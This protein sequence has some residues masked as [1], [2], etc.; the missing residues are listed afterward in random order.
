[1]DLETVTGLHVRSAVGK[2]VNV[3]AFVALFSVVHYT[4]LN[5]ISFSLEYCGVEPKDESLTP[6]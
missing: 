3:P 5:G 1:M 6:S 4:H 2:N